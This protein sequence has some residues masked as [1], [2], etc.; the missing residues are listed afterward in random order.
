MG[1]GA[2]T[3]TR[4]PRNSRF[5]ASTHQKRHVARLLRRKRP[6]DLEW[7]N[8]K[9]VIS[10]VILRRLAEADEAESFAWGIDDG[11]VAGHPL[12]LEIFI[13]VAVVN[14][15]HNDRRVRPRPGVETTRP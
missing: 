11:E 15:R 7:G 6:K 3:V 2:R 12:R 9:L 10:V 4:F 1:I 14:D 5:R 8:E 13:V